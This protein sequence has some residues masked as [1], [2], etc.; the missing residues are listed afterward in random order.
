MYKLLAFIIHS[1]NDVEITGMYTELIKKNEKMP[2]PRAGSTPV[3]SGMYA[4]ICVQVDLTKPYPSIFCCLPRVRKCYGLSA[5][6]RPHLAGR[7][8]RT[9][10]RAHGGACCR[11]D[12]YYQRAHRRWWDL[13]SLQHVD[14][15]TWLYSSW[16][17]IEFSREKDVP[18]LAAPWLLSTS[19][20][21]IFKSP[22]RIVMFEPSPRPPGHG[23]INTSSHISTSPTQSGGMPE[24]FPNTRGLRLGTKRW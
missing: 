17:R 1:L 13:D 21:I 2:D 5:G 24:E 19:F 11:V 6:H 8:G 12:G 23:R 18:V 15:Q 3:L 9:E 16:R 22:N 14:L 4:D 20:Q 10:W 7:L